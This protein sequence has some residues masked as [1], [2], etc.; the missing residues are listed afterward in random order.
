[1][2]NLRRGVFYEML[3]LQFIW[4]FEHISL[5]VDLK[6]RCL[7]VVWRLIEFSHSV[8]FRP[9]RSPI[10]C[11]RVCKYRRQASELVPRSTH[12]TPMA[13]LYLGS[14]CVNLSTN[15]QCYKLGRYKIR[16]GGTER[17][18]LFRALGK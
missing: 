7:R 3:L 18:K 8:Y 2:C 6:T 15:R 14:G 1:V 13:W 4:S 11:H 10:W 5:A 12:Q 16:N 17:I 9:A